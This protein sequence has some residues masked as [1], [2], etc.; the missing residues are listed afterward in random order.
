MTWAAPK[1]VKNP[2]T[3]LKIVDRNCT[4][5]IQLRMSPSA[6]AAPKITPGEAIT[7]GWSVDG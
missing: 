4:G 2:T 3:K 1:I 6:I 7:F 5:Q